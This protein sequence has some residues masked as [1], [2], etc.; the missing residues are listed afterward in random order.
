MSD[1]VDELVYLP[2][3]GAGEIGMNCYL[4]GY[5][6]RAKRRWI[7]VDLGMGFG[8]METSPGVDL[9]LPDIEFLRAERGRLEAIFL[10]HAHEDHV[11]AIPHLWDQLRVPIYARAFTAEVVRRKLTEAEMD[12]EAVR[13][14]SLGTRTE[15]GPFSVE[16][17]PVTHS[18]PEASSLVIR[19]PAGTVVHTGDFKLDP[20]PQMGPGID[21]AQFEALGREGVLA[22]ACDSTNVLL[23]GE[24][25][26]EAEIIPNLTRLIEDATGA[27]AATTFASNVA[28]LRTLAVAAKD[29]GRSIVV[30]GRAM[31]RMIEIA[32]ET[33][34]LT[35]FPGTVSEDQAQ[36]IPAENLFYLVTGS[37]GEGRAA[38]AR[39]AAGTHPSVTLTTGDTVLFS[40]KMIP[41]NEAGIY[42]LYN[43]LSENGINVVDGDMERIHVSGH[44]RRGDMK[45]VYEAVQPQIGLPMHGE[46]RHLVEHAKWAKRW[47]TPAALVAPNGTMM[48]LSG[49][50]PGTVEHIETGR[51][52]LDG[53]THVGA[54]DG[55][56]RERLKLARQGHV[57][58]SVVVDEEGE[59]VADPDVR[60]LG[61]PKDGPGWD[62]PLDEMMAEAVDTAIEDA[63][64][65]T[66]RSDNGVE[67]IAGRAVRRVANRYW[68]KRPVVTV[69]LTRLEA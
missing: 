62:A 51:T 8:D 11:G 57:V 60:C 69:L 9:V 34:Q 36:E 31:R 35:D 59:L 32:V 21:M 50:A 28:R 20:D 23:E 47:G 2:L 18:V 54:L 29:A 40:S 16:F 14:V 52:Y 3:G 46:H 33:G 68:G 26:S 48:R 64:L 66:R 55:V 4:Y 67:D 58:V 10:T 41:G 56:I 15:A 30:V 39:I 37:Q 25:G 63:P 17:L 6:P 65:K 42:R 13:Q 5:G 27:V 61:A 49:N 22:L 7:M 12:L 19:T 44:A 45:R 53:S 38:L 24:S 43:R 1:T